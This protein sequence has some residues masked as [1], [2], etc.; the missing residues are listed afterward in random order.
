VRPLSNC[1]ISTVFGF[2][3]IV[4]SIGITGKSVAGPIQSQSDFEIAVRDNSTS[5]YIVLLTVVDDRTGQS[6]TG[7]TEANFLLGAIILERL[8]GYGKKNSENMV[9]NQRARQIAL[10]NT[11]HVFHFSKQAAIDNLPFNFQEACDAIAH[12]LRARISDIG[13]VTLIEGR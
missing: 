9:K 8:N 7:C 2:L 10:E 5:P 11:S 12:G 6:R 1:R 13:G 4:F 3:L